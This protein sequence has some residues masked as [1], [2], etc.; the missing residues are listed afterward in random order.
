MATT[1]LPKAA[2]ENLPEEARTMGF[3]FL[4]TV[5]ASDF[6]EATV[7]TTETFTIPCPAN[8]TVGDVLVQL[9]TPFEN[10]ADAT[11]NTTTVGV[12]DNNSVTTWLSGGELNKNGSF[13]TVRRTTAAA[14][15]YTAAD[16]L[17]ITFT[18]KTASALTALN[19][20]EVRVYFALTG[21][22]DIG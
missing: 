1:V 8:K 16:A 10:T 14:K 12:G 9:V 13:V 17:K 11:N 18:P 7:S 22:G 19:K 3:T 6:T 5:K 2:L 15:V 20:G 4:A 21:P